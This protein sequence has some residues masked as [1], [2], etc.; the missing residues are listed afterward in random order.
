MG[1]GLGCVHGVSC[2]HGAVGRQGAEGRW[3]LYGC[4]LVLYFILSLCGAGGGIAWMGAMFWRGTVF[5]I[6]QLVTWLDYSSTGCRQYWGSLEM[7][8]CQGM[9]TMGGIFNVFFFLF[10]YFAG[11]VCDLWA[12]CR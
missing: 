1:G 7:W 2:L 9:F 12:D 4:R 10:S 8:S 5:S 3:Y 6:M 11:L